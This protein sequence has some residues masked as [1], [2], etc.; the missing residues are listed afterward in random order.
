MEDIK[1]GIQMKQ[2]ELTNTFMIIL[3][4]K[5]KV[6]FWFI[7]QI[8]KRIKGQPFNRQIIQFEFSPT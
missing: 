3:N 1:I 8:F 5:K 2:K 6:V 4:Q 7:Q